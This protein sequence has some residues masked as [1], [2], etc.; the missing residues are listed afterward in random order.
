MAKMRDAPAMRAPWMTAWPTPPQP[1]T[2]TVEPGSTWAVF[3]AAPTPV[4]TPQPMR[5]SCSSGR[6]VSTFTT[7]I[8]STVIWSANVPRP[9]KAG[10]MLPSLRVARGVN[11][12]EPEPS[13]RFD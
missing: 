12:T 4:V 7:D 10:A 2:A 6:S 1:M 9:V 5:A 13:H 8:W 11:M 3:R